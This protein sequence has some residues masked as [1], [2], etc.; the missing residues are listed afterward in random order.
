MADQTNGSVHILCVHHIVPLGKK[1][2][3]LSAGSNTRNLEQCYFLM[4]ISLGLPLTVIQ[5]NHNRKTK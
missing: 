3:H 1:K 2:V 5:N 4:N